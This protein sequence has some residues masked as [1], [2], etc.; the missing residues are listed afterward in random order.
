[1]GDGDTRL[2]TWGDEYDKMENVVLGYKCPKL[3]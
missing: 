3:I 2:C 1:M